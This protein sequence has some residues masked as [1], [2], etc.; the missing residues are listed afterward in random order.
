M[1][2]VKRNNKNCKVEAFTENI[3][4]GGIC[5][6]LDEDFGLFGQVKLEVF[7]GTDKRSILC[8][9]TIVWVVKRYPVSRSESIKYDTGIEFSGMSDENRNSIVNLV[10]YIMQVET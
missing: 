10:N 3:G 2:S 6:V 1:I 7:L 5:V 9:G 4:Q 8:D